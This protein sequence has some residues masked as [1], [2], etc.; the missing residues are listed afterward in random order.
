MSLSTDF[1]MRFG[2]HKGKTLS[3]LNPDYLNFLLCQ[4]WFN[5]KD[6]LNQHIKQYDIP[7]ILTFG[8]YKGRYIKEI[9]DE[10]Y[11]KFLQE[12]NI[13]ASAFF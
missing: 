5:N 4:E 3:E 8:K 10:S 11:C 1:K 9:D 2:K 6:I 7:L 12:K 13:V